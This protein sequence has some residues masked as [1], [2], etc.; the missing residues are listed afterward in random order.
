[1]KLKPDDAQLFMSL[2]LP[3]QW[4]VNQ[5]AKLFPELKSFEDYCE[6]AV[7]NKAAV[8]D[9]LF[10]HIELI[11]QFIQ[12]NP[13]NLNDEEIAIVSGWKTFVYSDFFIERMLK[14]HSI[15]IDDEDN[16]YGVLGITDAPSDFID[17]R[18]LPI[19]LQTTLL[20]FK[21]KVVSDGLYRWY[22][23]SFGGGIR[24]RLKQTYLI[25]KDNDD[26]IH[27]LTPT[28]NSSSDKAP[29]AKASKKSNQADQDWA[30]LL[31]ELASMAKKL[32]GGGGQPATYSP[33]FS[34]VRSSIELAQLATDPNPDVKKLDKK[35][36]RVGTLLNQVEDAIWREF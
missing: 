23:I 18:S 12:D 10:S 24:S 13:E 34:L 11:D 6:S 3:L 4:Y 9:Y 14:K 22:R 17:K 16:V 1:M 5:E 25:A 31:E 26:I 27:T 33:I 36:R 32:R 21:G 7:E 20:P 30:P 15:F 2:M 19:R 35:G 29:N 28:D 8:R